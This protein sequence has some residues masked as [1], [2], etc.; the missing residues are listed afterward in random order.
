ME[1]HIKFLE[2][3]YNQAYKNLDFETAEEL[4]RIKEI[5]IDLNEKQVSVEPEVK[6]ACEPIIEKIFEVNSHSNSKTRED[7]QI[8]I[9]ESGTRIFIDWRK[10]EFSITESKS[11]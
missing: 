3:L 6:P 11:V 5:L 9:G 2:H 4:Y 1:I 7:K 8:I 10:R